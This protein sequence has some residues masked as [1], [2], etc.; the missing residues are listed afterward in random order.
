MKPTKDRF[1]IDTNILVYANDLSEP[2]KR[3]RAREIIAQAFSSNLGCF[4]TQV[5]QEFYVVATRKVGLAQQ[6]ARAQ[7]IQLS[8]LNTVLIDQEIILAAIDLGI[9][10][11]IN[12]WDALIIK[13]AAVS[14]CRL[15]YT[16]DL[17][18]GQV[19]EGV[20]LENPFLS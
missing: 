8:K 20:L 17:N 16:E 5:L 14:G 1:F 10:H 13:S 18:H 6:N 7:V 3:E 2:A 15:L 19:I 12:F 4:S 11:Q 9:I